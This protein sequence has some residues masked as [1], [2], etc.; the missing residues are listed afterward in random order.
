[1]ATTYEKI[2]TTTLGAG[3][4][5]ILFSSI[6]ATY[7]DL[8]L[9]F[10]VKGSGTVRIQPNSDTS[11]LYSNTV[12]DGSGSAASSYRNTGSSFGIDAAESVSPLSSTIPFLFTVD[13]FSYAGN[14]FKTMLINSYGDKNGSGYISAMVGLYRSTSAI[15]SL[16]ISSTGN[17][18]L[19]GSTATLYGI[20]KA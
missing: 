19:T 8:R 20:L 2:A 16:N 14:T 11:A 7:T 10:V 1:M 3:A 4:A 18:Y 15:S 9:V 5:D 12:L 6:P 17:S 13:L